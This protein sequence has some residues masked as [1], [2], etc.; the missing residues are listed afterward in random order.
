MAENITHLRCTYTL[1]DLR[2]NKFYIYR[3]SP[4]F[5]RIFLCSPNAFDNYSQLPVFRQTDMFQQNN[6]V[7]HLYRCL[8][9][10]FS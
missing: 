4:V 8:C 10:Q 1:F 3:N 6:E 5:Q 9:Q 2:L 7:W